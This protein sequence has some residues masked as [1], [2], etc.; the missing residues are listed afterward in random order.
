M[1]DAMKI[2]KVNFS[3]A[4]AIELLALKKQMT[5]LFHG[6]SVTPKHSKA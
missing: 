4:A 1:I 5:Q 6:I 2:E 3:T